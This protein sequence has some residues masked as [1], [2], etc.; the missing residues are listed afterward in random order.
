MAKNPYSHLLK[1]KVK[2]LIS[3]V[4]S[5]YPNESGGK[6]RRIF[7]ELKPRIIAVT[8]NESKLLGVIYRSSVVS[9]TSRKTNATAKDLMEMP[10]YTSKKENNL[11]QAI[12]EMIKYDEWSSMVINDEEKL[13]GGLFLESFIKKSIDTLNYKLSELKVSEFMTKKVF[14]VSPE[15]FILNVIGKM[16]EKKYSG[17]PV[18]DQKKRLLGMITQYDIISKGLTRVEL[19]SESS[20]NKGAR[21]KK[22]MR[23]SVFYLY[24]WSSLIEASK[25]MIE[26]G[27]GRIPI[28]N[29]PHERLLVGIIDREDITK[30]IIYILEGGYEK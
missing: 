6:V 23:H 27:Y 17:L 30:A 15:D 24:P 2:D 13:V 3:S 8:N 19:E 9:L 7:R 16:I 12:K 26:K 14:S 5:V 11:I 10:E 20:P 4:I 29:N 22:V 21:V 25:A 1:L 18:I 28:V